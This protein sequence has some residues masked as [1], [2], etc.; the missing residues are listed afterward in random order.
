VFSL[1][2]FTINLHT[3]P[4]EIEAPNL[5]INII[6]LSQ[7]ELLKWMTLIVLACQQT[8]YTI[9]NHTP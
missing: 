1:I 4:V 5:A 9:T 6:K 8:W 7:K 3:E 2:N